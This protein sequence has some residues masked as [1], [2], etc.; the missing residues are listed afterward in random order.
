MKEISDKEF[1]ERFE[2]YRNTALIEP[3]RI[4]SEDETQLVLISNPLYDQLLRLYRK[5][6]RA[7][8]VSE[9]SETDIKSISESKMPPEHDHLNE[10]LED[11]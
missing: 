10:E 4:T 3:V 9:L 11:N 6:Q 8:H 7:F 2:E 1:I 5:E